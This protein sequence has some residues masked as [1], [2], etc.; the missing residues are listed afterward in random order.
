MG[1][2]RIGD[3]YPQL[4]P[5]QIATKD[6]NTGHVR[7]VSC[8][9]TDALYVP[10]RLGAE[11]RDL[12]LLFAAHHVEVELALTT[13]L[14]TIAL[15][16]ETEV[17]NHV[18]GPRDPAK[19]LEDFHDRYDGVRTLGWIHPFKW[20]WAALR[21]RQLADFATVERDALFTAPNM[22]WLRPGGRPEVHI[23]KL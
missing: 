2:A 17:L 11:F 20:T 16:A 18:N 19:L 14:D 6:A 22:T 10:G 21:E 1:D 9:L 7:G 12:A 13:I 4:T 15:R 8:D 5:R 3:L 23:G